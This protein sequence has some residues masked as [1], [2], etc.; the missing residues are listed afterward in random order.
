MI[1]GFLLGKFMPPH[2]GHQLLCET[3]A[4]LC[5]ALTIL[6]C[7]LPDD[8]IPGPLRLAWMSELCPTARVV[9]HGAVVPQEPHEHP[10]FWPI[11]RD[12]A[13]AAHPEPV[14]LV[15]ASEAYG[16]RLAIEL[17]ARFHPVD[18][19]RD[20]EPVS[21]SAVRADPLGCWP[22]LPPPVRAHY[23]R[24]ICLHGPESVG[25]STLAKALAATFDTLWAPEYGRTWCDQFGIDLSAADLVT[26]AQT[27]EALAA[28]LK[29][30]CN[31][32]LMLDTDPLMTAVW[33]DML[34]GRRDPWFDDWRETADL[35][36][37]LDTDLPWA[38][39][40]TRV[41]GGADD[42][43]RFL[44]GCRD[45]LTRR[46]VRWASVTGSGD[47]RIASAL[48]AIDAAGL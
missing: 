16:G 42:R 34:L 43:A 12:I 38:D 48:A 6:V 17:G 13:R 32:R 37:L 25:K 41:F 27:Q 33:S 3:A 35:Y 44:A 14:D 40:G 23:A 28:S 22:H 19:A 26:I 8:P 29:R 4:A 15:F 10:D 21:A 30:R 9:G 31:R 36:L 20:G 1:R 18:P 2:A 11:W 47:A 39:D 7:W 24:T 46:G 45:E 5:D